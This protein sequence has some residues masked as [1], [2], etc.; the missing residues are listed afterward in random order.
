MGRRTGA[1]G[2]ALRALYEGAPI[3]FEIL[4]GASKRSPNGI[5][6]Q[7][8]REGWQAHADGSDPEELERR[9]AVLSHR[10][11]S[12]LEE[13]S[14]EGS[15]ADGRYDKARIDA[16]SAMLRMVEKIGETTR[17]FERAKDNQNRTDEEM[18]AALRRINDR[19]LELARELAAQMVQGEHPVEA[20]AG[21]SG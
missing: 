11:V 12:E 2:A 21:D 15:G 4:G 1:T 20:G 9:L 6:A 7:A 13:I 19:I 3:T 16:L 10:L 5:K 8:A 18:A 17:V 14:A